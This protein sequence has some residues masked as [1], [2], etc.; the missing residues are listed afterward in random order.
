M[1]SII[2]GASFPEEKRKAFLEAFSQLKE[3]VLWKWET[4]YLPG[5]PEN[6]K[7]GKWLP[8]TDILGKLV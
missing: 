3:K 6:V 7:L 4:D 8:Q 2:K 1:G 5:K